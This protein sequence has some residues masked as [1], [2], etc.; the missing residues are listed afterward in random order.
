MPRQIVGRILL[1]CAVLL[2]QQ[3]ALAHD[4]W[5]ANA[6]QAGASGSKNPDAKKLCDLHDLLGTVLGVVSAVT[7]HTALLS[8]SDVAFFAAPERTAQR[9]LLSSRSRGPPPVS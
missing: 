9:R 7:P 4:L 1:V 2:A 3:T 5:H 8:L 6:A